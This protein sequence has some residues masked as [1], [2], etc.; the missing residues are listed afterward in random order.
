MAALGGK[1]GF[2]DER[3]RRQDALSRAL[4]AGLGIAEARHA[5]A[6]FYVARLMP[7]EALGVLGADDEEEVGA[8]SRLW[9]QAA[10]LVLADRASDLAAGI[11]E[12]ASCEGIDARLW[13]LVV[14]AAQGRL[15]E[16]A[17]EGSAI[18]LR[19]TEYPPDLRIELGL[20][21]AETAIEAPAPEAMAQLLDLVEEAAPADEARARLL[22]LRGRLAAARGDF[23]GAEASWKAA[24]GLPGAG[25]LRA[26]LALVAADLERGELDAVA[27][28]ADLE[29]LAYDWRR[30]PLQ[31]W[32][33]QLTAA[34][35]EQRGDPASALGV[36][37]EAALSEAGRPVGRA[38]VRLATD[39]MQRTYG[40]A[41][42]DVPFDQ[43]TAFW[44]YEG[45]VP[46]GAE[47]AG[48]RLAFA[49]TLLAQGLPAP[50]IGLLEPLVG[51]ADGAYADQAINLLA[52]AYLGADRPAQALDVLRTAAGRTAEPR[53]AR[54]R[55]AARALAALGRFAEAAGLLHGDSGE[56]AARQQ[57]DYLWKA[58][59][60]TEAAAAYRGLL[61]DG[62][63]E[64]GAEAAE[65]AVR[66]AAAAHMAGKPAAIEGAAPAV[67]AAGGEAVLSAFAPLPVPGRGK[68]AARAS[69]ARLLEQAR[70][71]EE[72]AQRYGLGAQ[73][74]Q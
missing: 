2:A 32:I 58:G 3:A 59:L 13:R 54:N 35:H 5:L 68:A 57:A 17:L 56:G 71:L 25:G 52:E 50:A 16:A 67:Q 36:L 15:P 65:A 48:V 37:E 51:G 30:H 21:L 55:L 29:R 49:R 7:H 8:P 39:L 23:A 22:F 47:G 24:A 44:R 10:A 19:L 43:M 4:A 6:G 38:A 53:T 9:L 11:L 26:T 41:A 72:I 42:G 18:V 61:R 20:R 40:E 70:G 74:G 31:L 46:P 34:V 62:G 64:G 45:F 12:D 69:A 60:W 63:Q 27:A 33:A 66:L 73:E 28:L 1:G 14:L